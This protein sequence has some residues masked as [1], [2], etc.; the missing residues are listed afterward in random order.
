MNYFELTCFQCMCVLRFIVAKVELLL[1]SES[2]DV[3]KKIYVYQEFSKV[4]KFSNVT[5]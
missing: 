3:F 5:A 1:V 2:L 4:L